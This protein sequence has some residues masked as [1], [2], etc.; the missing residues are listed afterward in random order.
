VSTTIK[1]ATALIQVVQEPYIHGV[2]T[3]E[4]GK[5][6]KKLWHLE[7]QPLSD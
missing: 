7:L 4:I 2:S 3:H 1:C 5:L 6:A